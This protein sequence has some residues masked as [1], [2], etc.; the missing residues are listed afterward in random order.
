MKMQLA[1]ILET[2]T[3]QRA[4][5]EAKALVSV[6]VMNS[7]RLAPELGL[8]LAHEKG[9][10][11]AFKILRAL[12]LPVTKHDSVRPKMITSPKPTK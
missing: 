5:D 9:V 2:V 3:F 1:A 11:T 4:A 8:A 10:H 12:T 6:D 7:D